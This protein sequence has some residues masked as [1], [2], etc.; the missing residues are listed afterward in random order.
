MKRNGFGMEAGGEGADGEVDVEIHEFY[1]RELAAELY[2]SHAVDVLLE[3]GPVGVVVVLLFI[4]VLEPDT[5]AIVNEPAKE[6]K[7]G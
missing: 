1:C 2:E 4:W 5:E 6:V 7:S 3:G